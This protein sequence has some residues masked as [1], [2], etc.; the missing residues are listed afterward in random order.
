MVTTF[1]DG[2]EDNELSFK[3]GDIIK[4]VE[5]LDESWYAGRLNVS[6]KFGMFPT[7]FTEELV[8]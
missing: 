7:N 1:L 5:K 2:Q 3:E 4:I 8:Q 6:T